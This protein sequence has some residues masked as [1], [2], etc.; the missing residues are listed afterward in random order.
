METKE[1]Y[2]KALSKYG[3]QAQSDM[4]IEE[5]G[6]VTEVILKGRRKGIDL[7][8]LADELADVIIIIEQLVQHYELHD[9]VIERKKFKRG[10]LESRLDEETKI[11]GDI[12]IRPGGNAPTDTIKQED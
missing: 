10:R 11:R 7:D 8:K 2:A 6:E 12:D 5:A 4:F 9:K 1:L 3:I